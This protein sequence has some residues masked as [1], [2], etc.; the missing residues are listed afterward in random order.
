[1]TEPFICTL[2]CSLQVHLHVIF[3][4]HTIYFHLYSHFWS[5]W[6]S[7]WLIDYLFALKNIRTFLRTDRYSV[8]K[9]DWH[10]REDELSIDKMISRL[11]TWLIDRLF[12]TSRRK[13][14]AACVRLVCEWLSWLQS[15]FSLPAACCGEG[16]SWHSCCLWTQL[17]C[18]LWLVRGLVDHQD[19]L[20]LNQLHH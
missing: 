15:C 3:E 8:Y 12:L 17:H 2:T 18:A 14:R 19:P 10:Q 1:M 9:T 16:L 5:I 11:I 4:I 20:G 6:S 7:M 13:H